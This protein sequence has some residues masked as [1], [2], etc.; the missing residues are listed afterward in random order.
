VHVVKARGD[1]F[2]R[3]VRMNNWKKYKLKS[4]TT[5]QH[6]STVG[7]A[8]NKLILLKHFN[9]KLWQ[10]C[11]W[12]CFSF[13]PFSFLK[14]LW[15]PPIPSFQWLAMKESHLLMKKQTSETM[16]P[17]WTWFTVSWKAYR[18]IN[19]V[20]RLNIGK[21]WN[22]KFFELIFFWAVRAASK[23]YIASNQTPLYVYTLYYHLN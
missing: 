14:N 22:M 8:T 1:S 10:K 13:L 2:K 15:F 5:L 21:G 11:L 19:E 17:S 7:Q 12:K 20:T 4:F 18:V 6:H 3:I 16:R 9:W 23:M